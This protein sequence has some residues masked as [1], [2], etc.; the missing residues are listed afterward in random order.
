ML[1]IRFLRKGK[2]NQ[3]FFKIVVTDKRRPPRG[4]RF[5][6]ELGFYNPLTKEKN[7]KKERAKYWISVGAKPSVTVYNLLIQEK[8]V[9]G[10]KI[11]VHKK[12]KKKE[13]TE[14]KEKTEEPKEEIKE[15]KKVVKK[16][17]PK[18]VPVETLTDKEEK[19]ATE[20]PLS[21]ETS[22]KEELKKDKQKEE[23][24]PKISSAE[25]KEDKSE[26]SK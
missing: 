12:S 26:T 11:S 1:V 7:I 21:K 4:G 13:K 19:P 25:A 15:K 17:E 24:K 10:K 18:S 20:K 5:L 3:P 23:K 9:E 8:V 22:L 14:V 6:E 2:K 16:E